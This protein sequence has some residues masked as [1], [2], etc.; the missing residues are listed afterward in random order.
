M[1]PAPFIRCSINRLT[2]PYL[3]P[4]EYR[5]VSA[6]QHNQ[7]ARSYKPQWLPAPFRLVILAGCRGT[8]VMTNNTFRFTRY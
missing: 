7:P 4:E 8:G 2:S 6:V 5:P 3:S 1:Y